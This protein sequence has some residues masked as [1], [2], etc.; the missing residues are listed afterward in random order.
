[1]IECPVGNVIDLMLK[2]GRGIK[3]EQNIDTYKNG[4]GIDVNSGS[5]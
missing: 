5:L 3:H 4:K 1:M 2:L